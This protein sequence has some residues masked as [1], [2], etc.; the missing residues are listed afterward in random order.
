[1][2]NS[3]IM[4]INNLSSS[5]GVINHSIDLSGYWGADGDISADEISESKI[6]FITACASGNHYYLNGNDLACEADDD[7]TYTADETN[8]TLDGTVFRLLQV[9]LAELD[10]SVSAFITNAVSD[11]VNY[12]TKSEIFTHINNNITSNNASMN[13]YVDGTFVPLTGGNLTGHY[14]HTQGNISHA[15]F[16]TDCYGPNCEGQI[17]YNGSSLV[18][19]VT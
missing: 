1:M 19:K 3:S 13:I 10:N 16:V 15:T 14:N 12:F 5:G 18:I 9:D 7:T 11:L 17:S 4:T 6:N 2:P 8:L